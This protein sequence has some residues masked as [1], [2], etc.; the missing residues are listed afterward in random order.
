[1]QSGELQIL[2]VQGFQ[3]RTKRFKFFANLAIEYVNLVKTNPKLTLSRLHKMLKNNTADAGIKHAARREIG[4]SV[5]FCK[6]L[7]K[8]NGLKNLV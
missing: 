8:G 7:P 2:V 3:L 5:Q 6:Q 1:M 4:L